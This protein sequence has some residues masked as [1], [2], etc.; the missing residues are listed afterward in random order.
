MNFPCPPKDQSIQESQRYLTELVS[1]R[2]P[3][4]SRVAEIKRKHPLPL[5]LNKSKQ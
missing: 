2:E 3:L 4:K 1:L 5:F